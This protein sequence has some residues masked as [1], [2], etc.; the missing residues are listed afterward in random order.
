M[1]MPVKGTVDP[2]CHTVS[3]QLLVVS[4][5]QE[6]HL[7]PS[8]HHNLNT[9]IHEKLVTEQAII[10]HFPILLDP[11]YFHDNFGKRITSL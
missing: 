3:C 1:V 10:I 7:L 2:S 11:A 8:W 5:V 6:N 4:V 9:S